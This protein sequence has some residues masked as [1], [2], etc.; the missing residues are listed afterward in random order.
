[1]GHVITGNLKIFSDSRLCSII[2][3]GPKY[4]F[5]MQIDFQKCHEKIAGSLNKFC[6]RWCNREHV[7]CDALKDWD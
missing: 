4:G 6:N 2:A 5:P 3:K 7:K 1:M